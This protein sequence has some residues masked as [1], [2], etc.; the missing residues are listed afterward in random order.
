MTDLLRANLPLVVPGW[1]ARFTA[2]LTGAAIALAVLGSR[3]EP[4]P[5]ARLASAAAATPVA[6][7]SAAVSAPPVIEAKV[8]AEA[9]A[10]PYPAPPAG[11]YF[12]FRIDDAAYLRLDELEDE[13]E[14]EAGD[15][16]PHSRA[17]LELSQHDGTFSARAPLALDEVPSAYR[18]WLGR[19]VVADE[20][21][22]A[23][24]AGF[25]L[26]AQLSGDPG[27][28]GEDS[29]ELGEWTAESVFEHGHRVIAARLDGCAGASLARDSAAPRLEILA[30]VT[31]PSADK[32]RAAATRTFFASKVAAEAQAQWA[33]SGGE[34]RWRDAATVDARVL[35][36]PG[37]RTTWVVIFARNPVDDCG[38][39]QLQML[40]TY[41]VG[42]DGGL[43]LV[44]QQL[45]D[46][47]YQLEAVLDSDGDGE[48]EMLGKS[49]LGDTR[50]LMS[51]RGEELDHFDVPFYGCPC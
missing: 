25:E 17:P 42:A 8:P 41:K 2:G 36:H 34:G 15:A 28:A 45:V 9:A 37:T 1:S 24:V 47:L 33:E 14:D 50:L 38:I 32:L 30:A 22:S 49:W 16:A 18:G 10:A 29:G 19:Q 40:A 7:L 23:W 5:S 46:G 21:C 20:R 6:M 13:L 51:P 4:K 39:P 44:T 12:V 11:A 27:Y 26:V 31:S 48:L 3:A 35:R 43:R